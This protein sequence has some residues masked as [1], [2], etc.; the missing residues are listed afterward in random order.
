MTPSLEQHVDFLEKVKESLIKRSESESFSK[1]SG[2][3]W[4]E[5]VFQECLKLDKQDDLGWEITNTKTA[6]FP[7]IVFNKVFGVEVKAT[8]DDHWTTLGNSINE[9]KRISTVESVYFFFGKLGGKF[10]ISYKPYEKCLKNIAT[11]HYPRYIVDMN[12][13]DGLSIFD[14]LGITYNDYRQLSGEQRIKMIKE[15]LRQTFAEGEALWWIDETTAPI[16]KNFNR[17][18]KKTKREFTI[19]AMA[20]CPEIFKGKGERGKYDRVAQILLTDYQA[21]SGNLRDHFS[22]SGK[23]QITLQDGRKITVPQMISQL[24]ANAKEIKREIL[25]MANEELMRDWDV[26]ESP[27]DRVISYGQLLN[28]IGDFKEDGLSTGDFFFDGLKR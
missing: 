11:T 4:E 19:L 24:H 26:K 6:E 5:L 25:A 9:S 21:V 17:L 16:I 20:R 23:E 28:V 13:M 22:A 2:E 27:E 7:D 1:L 18:D 8:K 15:Y 10:E 12:L 3:E 14:K